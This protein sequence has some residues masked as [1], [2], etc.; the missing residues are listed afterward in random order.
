MSVIETDVPVPARANS[1]QSLENFGK[2]IEERFRLGK[3]QGPLALERQVCRLLASK[4]VKVS[5]AMTC[6]LVEWIYG[7]AKEHVELT[8]ADGGPIEHTIR[9]G[10]GKKPAGEL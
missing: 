6:K 1:K 9:F 2:R 8:G 4:D 10:D 7:K 3:D 5:A